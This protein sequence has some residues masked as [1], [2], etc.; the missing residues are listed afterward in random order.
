MAPRIALATTVEMTSPD[1]DETLILNH[2]PEAELAAWDDPT[3]DWSTYDLVVVRST[4]N[5]AQ[6]VDEFRLWAAGVAKQSTLVNPFATLLWNSDKRYLL[7]LKELELPVVPT[8]F[9]PAGHTPDASDLDGDVVI[10]PAVGAGSLG[11]RRIRSDITEAQA[12]VQT[13]HE[14]GKVAMVQPYLEQVDRIGET[15][16]VYLGGEF[17]HAARKAAILSGGDSGAAAD[18]LHA[19]EHIEPCEATLAERYVA[20]AVVAS[21]PG[22]PHTGGPLPYARVDLLPTEDGPVILELELI[23]PSLFLQVSDGAAERAAQAIRRCLP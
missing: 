20:D 18:A 4:W 17:S 13:L 9:V 8:T 14:Q 3:I 10:K 6:R 23:E 22:V 1:I 19:E 16:M 12:H 7:D 2:L 5:Y 15:A 11:A 21:L